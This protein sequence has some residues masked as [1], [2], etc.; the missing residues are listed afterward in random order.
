MRENIAYGRADASDEDVR[1]AATAV[2]AAPFIEALPLG[3]DTPV[4]ERGVRLSIGQRQ[5]VA[6][7]RALLHDQPADPR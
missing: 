2:G 6:L 3:Y 7:A 1:A 5:L 4:Q